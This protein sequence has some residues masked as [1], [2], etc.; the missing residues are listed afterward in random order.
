MPTK[1]IYILIAL[2]ATHTTVFF[3]GYFKKGEVEANKTTI[4]I[5]E[6]VKK[7]AKV[8]NE[9]IEIG[10]EYADEKIDIKVQNRLNEEE[11]QRRV[12]ELT[13]NISCVTPAGVQSIN[14]ALGYSEGENNK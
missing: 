5:T 13:T 6:K 8:Q 4:A 14:K 12:K 10:L 2:L 9:L 1:Y 3:A 7:V 11:V